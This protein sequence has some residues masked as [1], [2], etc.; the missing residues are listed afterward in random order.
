M[1]DPK[2][3]RHVKGVAVSKLPQKLRIRVREIAKRNHSKEFIRIL[4]R[5]LRWGIGL[6]AA[7]M[8]TREVVPV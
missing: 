5:N 1:S 7:L 8:R 2:T 4:V 3:I 6:T